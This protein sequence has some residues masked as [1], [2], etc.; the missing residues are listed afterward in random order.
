MRNV[1]KRSFGLPQN[2][3]E[4]AWA[5]RW[6]WLDVP[7]ILLCV[8]LVGIVWL[9]SR[10]ANGSPAPAGQYGR[11]MVLHE[12]RETPLD[13]EVAGDLVGLP[14]GSVRYLKRAD[15]RTFPPATFLVRHDPNFTAPTR[16]SG[17]ELTALLRKVSA[18]PQTDMIVAVCRDGYHAYYR[19]SYVEGHSPLLALLLDN[20]PPKDWPTDSETHQHDIGPFLITH[21]DFQPA[22]KVLGQDEVAQIPWGVVRLEFRDEAT[23]YRAIAPQGPQASDADVQD[24][25][26]VAQQNCFRCHDS[27]AEGGQTAQQPWTVLASGART[28]PE[29]FAAYVRD[30]RAMNANAKMPGN[31]GFDDAT[32]QALTAYFRTFA[33]TGKR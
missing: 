19:H 11:P 33:E 20:K 4:L 28:S 18:H 6:R 30:P 22:Y 25:F 16:V 32:L 15:L 8:L 9:H 14:P 12:A 29:H 27:G 17:V 13:L 10:P 1:A 21:P 26:R 24:G 2:R 3:A 31:P 5:M 7:F 23:V